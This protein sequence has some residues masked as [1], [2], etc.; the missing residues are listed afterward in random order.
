MKGG[1]ICYGLPMPPSQISHK[2]TGNEDLTHC[3]N[4]GLPTVLSEMRTLYGI[5]INPLLHHTS[6]PG[7]LEIQHKMRII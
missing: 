7:L 4:V 2:P 6:N 1:V 3:V 5:N